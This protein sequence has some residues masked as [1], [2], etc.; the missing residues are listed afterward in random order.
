ML[1]QLPE[2]MIFYLSVHDFSTG[3]ALFLYSSIGGI[4][5]SI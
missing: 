2:K 5:S 4:G 3:S 1:R